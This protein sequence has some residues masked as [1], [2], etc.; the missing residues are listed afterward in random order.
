MDVGDWTG[1]RCV[2]KRVERR[3]G[4]LKL[5]KW[6]PKK[7]AR[8]LARPEDARLLGREVDNVVW[9][10]EVVQD[11][12]VAPCLVH[13]HI[14]ICGV[15]HP[16]VHPRKGGRRRETMERSTMG[17]EGRRCVPLLSALSELRPVARC[18]LSPPDHLVSH[19]VSRWV[20]SIP[21]SVPAVVS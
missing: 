9:V 6:H 8:C 15:T 12:E 5:L 16:P 20:G 17:E 13:S 3:G 11:V 7:R 21:N 4:T 1:K 19:V 10:W 14:A 18:I 2:E